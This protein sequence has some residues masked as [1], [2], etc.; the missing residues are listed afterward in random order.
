MLLVRRETMSS[1]SSSQRIHRREPTATH[2]GPSSD[3]PP[4]NS[5]LFHPAAGVPPPPF[6]GMSP[7]PVQ[8]PLINHGS[9]RR[10]VGVRHSSRVAPA[11]RGTQNT[12]N[13]RERSS[14]TYNPVNPNYGPVRHL[15]M[16]P[17]FRIPVPTGYTL[18][19]RSRICFTSDD[20]P[21]ILV[22]ECIRTD[23]T[24]VDAGE[25]KV[26]CL[27]AY[28]RIPWALMWPGYSFSQPDILSTRN[29]TG[30]LITL[31][32]LASQICQAL[33]NL[34]HQQQVLSPYASSEDSMWAVGNPSIRLNQIW[35]VAFGL[36]NEEPHLWVP[37]FEVT[38]STSSI[39]YQG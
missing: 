6:L 3:Y 14:T 9:N 32:V 39:V 26:K 25:M 38:P 22:S 35:L 36:S 1:R 23:F 34:Q 30:S 13:E 4:K 17:Q 31:R 28:A 7:S 19:E 20:E 27:E 11:S 2:Q 21:G 29:G 24:N 10:Q 37:E 15:R 5:M 16:M 12:A 8:L 33:S 18:S